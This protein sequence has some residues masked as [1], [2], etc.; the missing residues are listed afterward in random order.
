MPLVIG[1]ELGEEPAA[2]EAH[3]RARKIRPE[4]TRGDLVRVAGAQN[5]AEAELIQNL[6]GV[7]RLALVRVGETR[8]H[9]G[10]ADDLVGRR[11]QVV[12]PQAQP[13]ILGTGSPLAVAAVVIV[14]GQP[15]RPQPRP[16]RAA[17]AL[18]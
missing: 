17:L 13:L 12:G 15:H 9:P 7:L 14:P 16:W 6:L 8:L 11:R 1:S 10:Q 18:R 2:S 3:E 4:Y 5:Q